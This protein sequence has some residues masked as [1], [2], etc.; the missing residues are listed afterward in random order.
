MILE[1]H[2]GSKEAR[3]MTLFTQCIAKAHVKLNQEKRIVCKE[4]GTDINQSGTCNDT[5]TNPECII[6]CKLPDS[7]IAELQ[8]DNDKFE[9]ECGDSPLKK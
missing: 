4:F 3:A 1:I 7:M 8:K 5:R 6:D 2:R 9:A